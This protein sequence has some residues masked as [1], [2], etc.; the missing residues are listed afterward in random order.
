MTTQNFFSS[1][2]MTLAYEGGYSNHPLDPGAATN[3]GVTQVVY[4]EDRADRDLPTRDVRMITDAEVTRIY[5]TRYWERVLAD[6]LAPGL[7]YAMFDFAVNSGVRVAVRKLQ[8][9]VATGIDGSMGPKTLTATKN[10]AITYGLPQLIDYLCRERMI[11]LRKLDTFGTF[12][13]G[14]TTRV[15]GAKDGAQIDDTGVIDRAVKMANAAAVVMPQAVAYTPKT[16][17]ATAVA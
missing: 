3:R 13:H 11:F 14:W 16:Y 4:N 15:M 1:L 8:G 9:I 7:D 6:D 5:R 10:Y 17:S 12:G 2:Q